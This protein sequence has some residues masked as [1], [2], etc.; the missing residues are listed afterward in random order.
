MS[1]RPALSRYTGFVFVISCIVC[2]IITII[3]NNS[4]GP[5]PSVNTNVLAWLAS[6]V[7]TPFI[8]FLGG[9]AVTVLYWA[10]SITIEAIMTPNGNFLVPALSIGYVVFSVLIGLMLRSNNPTWG[11]PTLAIVTVL[12]SLCFAGFVALITLCWKTVVSIVQAFL[13]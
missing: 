2:T 12:L 3:W 5:V 10:A 11:F 6:L 1:G 7:C 13:G 8:G 9:T 4:S